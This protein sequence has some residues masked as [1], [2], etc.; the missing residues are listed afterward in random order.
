MKFYKETTEDGEYF[1]DTGYRVL[2]LIE[3]GK[4]KDRA[5]TQYMIEFDNGEVSDIFEAGPGN[6]EQ[7]VKDII[8]LGPVA[9]R[10]EA[11]GF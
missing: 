2:K 10:L 8:A 7:C 5:S 11:R 6:I 3:V 9:E 4:L 1:A